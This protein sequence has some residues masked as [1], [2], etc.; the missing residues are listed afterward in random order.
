LE[1]DLCEG[2]NDEKPAELTPAEQMKQAGQSKVPSNWGEGKV[3][4]KGD[5]WRWQDPNNVGNNVRIMKGNP[6]SPKPEQQVDYVKITSGGKVID[7]NA[8]PLADAQGARSHIPLSNWLN[9]N[10]WNNW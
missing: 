2:A 8:N 1:Y 6:N 7:T 3:S 9:W 5:G 4:D 10:S